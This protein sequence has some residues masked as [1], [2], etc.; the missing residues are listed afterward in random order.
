MGKNSQ[1]GLPLTVPTTPMSTAIVKANDDAFANPE[2]D[3]GFSPDI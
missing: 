3:R 2:L 1:V